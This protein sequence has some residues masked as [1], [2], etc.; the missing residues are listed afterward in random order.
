MDNDHHQE[1]VDRNEERNEGFEQLKD[2][3]AREK[4]IDMEETAQRK[5]A[6]EAQRLFEENSRLMKNV[7]ELQAR[8]GELEGT[9]SKIKEISCFEPDTQGKEE[10]GENITDQDIIE[11]AYS[12]IQRGENLNKE[13]LMVVYQMDSLK[14]TEEYVASLEGFRNFKS[15]KYSTLEKILATRDK[16]NDL[17]TIYNCEKGEISLFSN[18]A[19][20]KGSEIRYHHGPLDLKTIFGDRGDIALPQE[21]GGPVDLRNVVTIGGNLIMPKVVHGFFNLAKLVRVNGMIETSETIEGSLNIGRYD[22]LEN[23]PLPRNVRMVSI[24][25]RVKFDVFERIVYENPDKD[26]RMHTN[27]CITNAWLPNKRRKDI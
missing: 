15:P 4:L 26:I 2:T 13:E 17:A 20:Q 18:E 3:G 11:L 12:K 10:G 19:L 21:V 14:M 22:N 16:R 23:F 5:I 25:P 8:V 1:A 24:S 27:N 6:Y 9:L 7:N